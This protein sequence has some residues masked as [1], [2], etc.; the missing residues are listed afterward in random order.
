MV[1]VTWDERLSKGKEDPYLVHRSQRAKF[2]PSLLRVKRLVLCLSWQDG[3]QRPFLWL[4]DWHDAEAPNDLHKSVSRVMERAVADGDRR[5]LTW[6]AACT[7]GG[8][9]QRGDGASAGTH[10]A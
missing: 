5:F 9:G 6:E 1:V 2:P 8:D 10:M 7:P 4:A 3:V